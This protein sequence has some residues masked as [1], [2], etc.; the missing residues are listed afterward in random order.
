M[1][2]DDNGLNDNNQDAYG[3]SDRRDESVDIAPVTSMPRVAN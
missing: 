2:W 1:F 3:Y